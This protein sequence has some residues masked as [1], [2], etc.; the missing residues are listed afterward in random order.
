MN[1]NVIVVS[2][3]RNENKS[4][5]PSVAKTTPE[6]VKTQICPKRNINSVITCFTLLNLV[7]ERAAKLFR[8]LSKRR[9]GARKGRGFGIFEHLQ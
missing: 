4:R 9:I 8:E 2:G 6:R 7:H 3:T 1:P 5:T